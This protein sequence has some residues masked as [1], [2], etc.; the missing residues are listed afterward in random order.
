MGDGYL[1]QNGKENMQSKMTPE[2]LDKYISNHIQGVFSVSDIMVLKEE[3]EKLQAG[4]LYVEIGVD[5]GRSARVAHE[6]ADP[7]VFKVWIDINDPAPR[8]KFMQKEGMVGIEK[9]GFH[10]HGDADEFYE[11][12]KWYTPGIKL[13]F[14][15]G[16]HDYE[17]VKKNTIYWE[18]LIKRVTGGELS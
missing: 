6:Y 10:V 13:L 1:D 17:S 15:D 3:I 7:G 9:R 12:L 5:E 11:L 18:E 2:Q 16:H 14:I 8:A 4:D